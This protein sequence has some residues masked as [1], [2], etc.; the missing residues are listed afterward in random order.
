MTRPDWAYDYEN[1]VAPGEAEGKAVAFVDEGIEQVTI[2][3]E[4]ETFIKVSTSVIG[5]RD[6]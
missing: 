5:S 1:H 2:G 4:D 3:F 6:I